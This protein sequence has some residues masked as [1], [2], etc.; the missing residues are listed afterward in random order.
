[1]SS[2]TE[3]LMTIR[4]THENGG[5]NELRMALTDFIRLLYKNSKV[6]VYTARQDFYAKTGST[7]FAHA[8]EEGFTIFLP[9]P[10]EGEYNLVEICKVEGSGT[11]HLKTE[12]NKDIKKGGYSITEIDKGVRLVSNGGDYIEF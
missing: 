5:T 7:V 10:V 2:K 9:N 12:S 4:E 6:N 8:G 11:I 1:M 3:F